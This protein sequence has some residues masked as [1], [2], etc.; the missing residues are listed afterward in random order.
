MEEDPPEPRSLRL[1]RRLVTV[2]TAT[3]IAGMVA[4]VALLWLRTGTPA[5]TLPEE[6][7]LPE[8]ASARAVTWGTGWYAVVTDDDEILIFDR[9]DGT[10][11]Q[12]VAIA[13]E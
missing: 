5:P 3:M 8:G 6:I 7:R 10:L 11:R 13:S 4:L 2:L 1:L 9:A 12:R